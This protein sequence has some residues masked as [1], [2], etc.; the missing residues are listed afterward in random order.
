MIIKSLAF[1]ALLFTTLSSSFAAQ[2]LI[3]PDGKLTGATGVD[4]NGEYY[5]V[6]FQDDYCS[7]IFDGCDFNTKFP[8]QGI[9]EAQS[10]A[11]ALIQQVIL[12]NAEGN[13]AS[14]PGLIYGCPDEVRFSKC[15][16]ITPRNVYSKFTGISV[17][18]LTRN[19]DNGE[20]G[21]STGCYEISGD[22]R[23]IGFDTSDFDN[24]AISDKV[25]AKWTL[26]KCNTTSRKCSSK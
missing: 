1:A 7:A 13:Y 11:L 3:N 18:N 21:C 25:Y 24:T 26:S 6:T 22:V 4:V 9:G 12:D 8:F 19:F 23:T 16:I 17:V 2:P 10:A 5:D 15:A 14:E 20:D